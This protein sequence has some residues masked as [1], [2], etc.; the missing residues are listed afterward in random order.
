MTI[1]SIF[2]SLNTI[3][4]SI[5]DNLFPKIVLIFLSRMLFLH[6]LYTVLTHRFTVNLQHE[7]TF[8]FLLSV[9]FKNRK[10]HSLKYEKTT[11]DESKIN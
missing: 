5:L 6:N 1:R 4:R 3:K 11:K 10:L 2:H 8:Y 7:N 9:S